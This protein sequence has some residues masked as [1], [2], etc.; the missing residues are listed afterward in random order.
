MTEFS[1]NDFIVAPSLLSADFSNLEIEIKNLM[2]GGVD[3]IH[4]DIMDGHFVPNL[5]IGPPV[6]RSLRKIK[7]IFLDCHL[8]IEE[9]EKYLSDFIKA[10]AD[11]ITLHLESRGNMGQMIAEIKEKEVKVGLTLKPGTSL[12]KI[13]PYL[14]RVDMVLIMTVE[15]G[16]GG[17]VFME[18]QVVKINELAEIRQ[19]DQLKYLIQVDGGVNGKTK[20]KLSKADVLVAGS[21]IFKHPES[22]GKAIEELKERS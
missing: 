21:F 19:K 6:V 1:L 17:Q 16:F 4:L 9:P 8:M 7:N 14:D 10:G 5:T 3:W 22:Y 13:K 18:D 12:E 15:P 11:N 2:K 20:K